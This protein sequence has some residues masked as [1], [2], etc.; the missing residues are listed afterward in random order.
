MRRPWTYLTFQGQEHGSDKVQRDPDAIL[1]EEEV[2]KEAADGRNSK[3][4]QK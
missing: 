4:W 3:N 2:G 1:N